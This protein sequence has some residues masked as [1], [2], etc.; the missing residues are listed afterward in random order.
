M[1]ITYNSTT[2]TYDST[3]V[4][5]NG[6]APQGRPTAFKVEIMFTSGY[7]DDAIL[8]HGVLDQGVP[9]LQK[10]IT[11]AALMR[12]VRETLDA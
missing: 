4:A 8:R 2:T 7:T 9:F 6:G 5:Y 10:P 12:S 3:T 1:T 11:P